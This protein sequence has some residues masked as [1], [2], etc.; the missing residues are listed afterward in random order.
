MKSLTILDWLLYNIHS[1]GNVLGSEDTLADKA[2]TILP[3]RSFQ[4]NVTQT[5]AIPHEQ[6]WAVSSIPEEAT[7]GPSSA[8]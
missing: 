6:L 2:D 4:S 3:S 7:A 1:L 8:V 5:P